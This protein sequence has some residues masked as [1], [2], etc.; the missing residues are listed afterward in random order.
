[1]NERLEGSMPVKPRVRVVM[2]FEC[3]PTFPENNPALVHQNMSLFFNTMY[4]T[5]L[6]RAMR[7]ADQ[8]DLETA[9]AYKADAEIM[10]TMRESLGTEIIR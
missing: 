10:K 9:K 3:T 5:L 6:S 8:H 1:M 2:E 4:C 7:A